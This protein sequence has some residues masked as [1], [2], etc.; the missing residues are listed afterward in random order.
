MYSATIIAELVTAQYVKLQKQETLVHITLEVLF[1][2]LSLKNKIWAKL[3]FVTY[4]SP[5][6]ALSKTER[7]ILFKFEIHL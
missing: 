4:Y 5:D 2:V 7:L 3:E 6:I 1:D